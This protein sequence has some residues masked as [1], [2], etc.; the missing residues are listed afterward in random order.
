MQI[1]NEQE[2]EKPLIVMKQKN[3]HL[4]L[5]KKI[6][7]VSPSNQFKFLP[8]IISTDDISRLF[9]YLSKSNKPNNNNDNQDESEDFTFQNKIDILT[10]LMTLFRANKNLISLFINKFKSNA[11]NFYELIIDIYLSEDLK[12]DQIVDSQSK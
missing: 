9:F 3:N 4:S 5:I 6:F 1:V 8:L 11:T 7:Y 12:N 10:I 2:K